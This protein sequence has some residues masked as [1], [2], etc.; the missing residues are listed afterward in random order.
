MSKKTTPKIREFLNK[1]IHHA[2]KILK[3]SSEEEIK[4]I[5]N[6]PLLLVRP[7]QKFKK[8][9]GKKLRLEMNDTENMIFFDNTENGTSTMSTSNFD[10][11][12]TTKPSTERIVMKNR[13]SNTDFMINNSKFSIEKKENSNIKTMSS[14]TNGSKRR[15]KSTGN[16]LIKQNIINNIN[17]CSFINDHRGT[18]DYNDS[19]EDYKL[20]IDCSFNGI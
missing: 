18:K 13:F 9:F 8:K 14:N 1:N 10:L 12:K 19:F 3:N 7:I 17:H 16:I 20:S 5:I 2:M 11:R 15:N 4:Y 6:N